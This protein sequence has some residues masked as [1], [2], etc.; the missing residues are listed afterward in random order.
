[1]SRLR[2]PLWLA[3]GVL[4]GL[5]ACDLNP[6]PVPPLNDNNK[7]GS[8]VGPGGP[9]LGSDAGSGGTTGMEG[10]QPTGGALNLGGGFGQ[11]GGGGAP[12][13]GSGG[14]PPVG[15]GGEGGEGPGMG[16]GGAA[17][18]GESSGGESSGGE[19]S[20]GESSGGAGGAGGESA[21]HGD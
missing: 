15:A 4:V 10:P 9:N 20:G 14:M 19:A 13:A 17:S 3:L 7:G 1:M 8:G 6:Q 18:G 16:A 2:S 21:L 12:G 11:A 5:G